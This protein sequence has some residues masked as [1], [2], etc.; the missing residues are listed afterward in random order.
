MKYSS[1][2]YMPNQPDRMLIRFR[3]WIHAKARGGVRWGKASIL[4]GLPQR[5][6]SK[7]LFDVYNEHTKI[8]KICQRSIKTFGAIRNVSAALAVLAMTIFHR[9]FLKFAAGTVFALVSLLCH[10]FL[11]RYYV[12]EFSHQE[13][14]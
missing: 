7:E 6:P 5:L 13:N 10:N 9:I 3:N 8:C 2:Y 1:Q 4:N 14:S 11:K 12:Y